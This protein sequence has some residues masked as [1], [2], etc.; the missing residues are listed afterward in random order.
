MGLGDV[1]GDALVMTSLLR[2][3]GV[4]TGY[5][6]LSFPLAI[7]SFTMLVTG[8]SL[9]AG[10]MV[11]LLGLPVLIATLY[12]ARGFAAVKRKQLGWVT[13]TALTPARYR[14]R[15]GSGVRSW[16]RALI[17]RQAWLDVLHGLLVFP[18]A[19]FTW[20]VAVTWWA[21]ALFGVSWPLFGHALDR[22]N[23]PDSQ[24]LPQLLGIDTYA[25]RSLF[26]VGIGLFC[27]LTL[28][29]V[30]RGLTRLHVALGRGLLANSRVAALQAR[31]EELRASRDATA[32][33]EATSLRRLERDLH[34]GPQQRLT[35]IAMDL[36]IVQRRLETDPEAAK[37][38]LDEALD[39]TREAIAEVRAL[40]R[41]IAPPILIDRGLAAALAAVAARATVQ[42]ELDVR[43]DDGERLPNAVENAAYFVVAEALTNVAKHAD[44]TTCA[45]VVRRDN[46]NVRVEISDNGHGGAHVSKGHGLAG[47][48][49]RV[50][51]LG[52]SLT[53]TSPAG[54]PTELV[55]EV[56]CA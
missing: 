55:A 21:T 19:T 2:R 27:L 35:R 34:D 29:F 6:F 1:P 22:T 10:L 56:P 14:S 23:D 11:T 9:G 25:H 52:G 53:I 37:P 17:D 26:Y 30:I 43:L 28:P 36:G 40:S 24:D 51:G 46:G 5:L 3:L 33:A 45:V 31:V 39:Q 8:L 50:A 42:V 20:S 49:D 12:V 16:L 18:L 7:A 4:E 48:D 41:G 44:A 15:S 32:Q 13:G 47:L 54:G 38:L